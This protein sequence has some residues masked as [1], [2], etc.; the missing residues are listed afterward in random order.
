MRK[1]FSFMGTLLLM[2]AFWTVS[3]FSTGESVAAAPKAGEAKANTPA[4]AVSRSTQVSVSH[5]GTDTIGTQLS[6][7]LKELFNASNL[8]ELNEKSAPK[9]RLILTSKAEF[10]DRP[11][12]GSVYSLLWVFSQSESHLGYLLAQ[13]VNV[14]S[15]EDIDAVAA[16]IIEQ[17]DGLSVK[18]GY[19][20]K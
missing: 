10:T 17:T 13:E 3:P 14:L 5:E 12:V 9:I 18:Y 16:K 20:F 2:L 11:H 4:K 15:S 8:F 19:L 6:T 7:R 1:K